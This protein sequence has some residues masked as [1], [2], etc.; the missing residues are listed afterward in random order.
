M[1]TSLIFLAS[2]ASVFALPM[3]FA[4]QISVLFVV[5]FGIIVAAD[6]R[7]PRPSVDSLMAVEATRREPLRLA[8]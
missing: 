8:A 5:G 4:T 6:Y 7:K 3:D 1:K 2:L